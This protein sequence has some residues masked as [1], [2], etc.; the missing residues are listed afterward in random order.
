MITLII[1]SRMETEAL[2]N[3]LSPLFFE[4]HSLS[5]KPANTSSYRGKLHY[6]FQV[7]RGKACTRQLQSYLLDLLG[8]YAANTLFLEVETIHPRRITQNA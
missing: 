1:A 7:P 6:L 4:N 5:I 2:E 8:E 3:Y